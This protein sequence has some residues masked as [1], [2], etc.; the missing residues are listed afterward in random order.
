[1]NITVNGEGLDVAENLTVAE[2]VELR[3]DGRSGIAIAVDGEL[4]PRSGWSQQRLI[5]GAAIE[6]LTA[7]QGG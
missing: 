3:F 5:P 1:M 4:A 2:L 7:V 6:V